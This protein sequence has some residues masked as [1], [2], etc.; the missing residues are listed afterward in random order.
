MFVREFRGRPGNVFLYLLKARLSVPFSRMEINSIWL[1]AYLWRQLKSD[2]FGIARNCATGALQRDQ[3]IQADEKVGITRFQRLSPI[4]PGLPRTEPLI[5]HLIHYHS[6]E[7][8]GERFE[9][10]RPGRAF[11]FNISTPDKLA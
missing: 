8:I 5:Q 3:Q 4:P 1:S 7:G 6:G 9:S 10:Y 2:S 11:V